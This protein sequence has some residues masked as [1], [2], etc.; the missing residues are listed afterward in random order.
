M[1]LSG[2]NQSDMNSL[3]NNFSVDNQDVNI[4]GPDKSMFGINGKSLPLPIIYKY[5]PIGIYQLYSPQK[6]VIH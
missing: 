2:V 5:L 3:W 1:F 4:P 6:N